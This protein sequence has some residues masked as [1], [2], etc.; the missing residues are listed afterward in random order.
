LMS[1]SRGMPLFIL[2]SY[3]SGVRN[4]ARFYRC[5]TIFFIADISCGS[6]RLTRYRPVVQIHLHYSYLGSRSCFS[7]SVGPGIPS[8]PRSHCLVSDHLP[9]TSSERIVPTQVLLVF[10]DFALAVL[11][12]TTSVPGNTVFVPLIIVWEIFLPLFA[13]QSC[14]FINYGAVSYIWRLDE[15]ARVILGL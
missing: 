11:M 7:G 2:L 4:S 1:V 12:L 8:G 9:A 13:L 6:C 14:P 10:G 3:L 5:S 15:T